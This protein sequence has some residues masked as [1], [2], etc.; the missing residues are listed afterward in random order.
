MLSDFRKRRN[1]WWLLLYL[2]VLCLCKECSWRIPCYVLELLGCRSCF[3]L[4]GMG[5]LYWKN[6]HTHN[7]LDYN[8]GLT[9]IYIFYPIDGLFWYILHAFLK[10]GWNKRSLGI[11]MSEQEAAFCFA[12]ERGKQWKQQ[13]HSNWSNNYKGQQMWSPPSLNAPFM[14]KWN[15]F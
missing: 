10:W 15:Y 5:K 13:R 14:Q 2:E 6:T 9:I 8:S 7:P 11:L 12:P 3:N 4:K 1:L